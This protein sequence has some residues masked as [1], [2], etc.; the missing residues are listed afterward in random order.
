MSVLHQVHRTSTQD[1]FRAHKMQTTNSEN[2][3]SGQEEEEEE[4]LEE[5]EEEFPQKQ[6]LTSHF[7]TLSATPLLPSSS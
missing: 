5:E 6:P 3:N 7:F 4:E 1:N 2:S